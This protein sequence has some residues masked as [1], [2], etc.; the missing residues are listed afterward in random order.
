RTADQKKLRARYGA[1]AS[2]IPDNAWLVTHAPFSGIRRDKK[3]GPR[4][5]NTV[6][7][8]ALGNELEPKIKMIVSGHIHLFEGLSFSDDRPP[9][10]VVG[11][12]GTN[13]AKAPDGKRVPKIKGLPV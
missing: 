6:L 5:D 7:Q 12:G 13:L 8:K 2:A 10:L 9:Q 1:V 4:V 3:I 11:S